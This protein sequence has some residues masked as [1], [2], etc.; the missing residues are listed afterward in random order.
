MSDSEQIEALERALAR[1][2]GNTDRLGQ[3]ECPKCGAMTLP[4]R[5]CEA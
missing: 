3:V 2:D 4:C 5:K 1:A